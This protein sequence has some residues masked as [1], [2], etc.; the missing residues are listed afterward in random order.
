MAEDRGADSYDSGRRYAE[1]FTQQY[2]EQKTQGSL[3]GDIDY[4]DSGAPQGS[5]GS[6][7]SNPE[8]YTANYG[9]D[10][11]QPTEDEIEA[12]RQ[13]AEGALDPSEEVNDR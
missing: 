11:R 4:G 9:Q 12:A 1:D 7:D 8:A 5:G 2:F 13:R 6:V 10:Y 3:G